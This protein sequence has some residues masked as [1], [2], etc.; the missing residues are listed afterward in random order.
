MTDPRL[1]VSDSLGRRIVTVEKLPFSIGRRAGSDLHLPNA[2]V[3]RDHSEIIANCERY[4]IRDCVCRFNLFST[5]TRNRRSQ[6][7]AA[8]SACFI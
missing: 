4:A 6:P 7:I 8:A 3:S 5:P 1:E 2:E